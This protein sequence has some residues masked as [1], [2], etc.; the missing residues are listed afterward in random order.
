MKTSVQRIAYYTRKA[1][2]L[3]ADKGRRPNSL[4]YRRLMAYKAALNK[5]LESGERHAPL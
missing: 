4:R 5:R 2:K 3:S 1:A